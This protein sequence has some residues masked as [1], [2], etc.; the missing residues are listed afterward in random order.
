M[1]ER[2]A[3]IGNEKSRTL[4]GL[5]HITRAHWG[6]KFVG[7]SKNAWVSAYLLLSP[8]DDIVLSLTNM[9]KDTNAD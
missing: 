9:G 7:V 1:H 3:A 5:H 8:N 4:I 6:G 2:V